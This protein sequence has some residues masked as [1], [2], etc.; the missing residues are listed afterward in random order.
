M[1]I[2]DKGEEEKGIELIVRK[3]PISGSGIARVHS[4]IIDLPEF[5]EGK[6]ALIEKE[7]NHRVLRLVADSMMM[8]GRISIRQKDMDKLKVKE[9]EKVKMLPV[10]GVGDHI[11][12]R[13]RFLKK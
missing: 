12:K 9:G 3:S 6:V 5:N 8:K 10:K 4:S 2:V 13:F 11:S 1:V 7:K